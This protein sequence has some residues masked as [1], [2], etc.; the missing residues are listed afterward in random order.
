[1]TDIE[2][3]NYEFLICLRTEA[4]RD[5]PG[6]CAMFGVDV[7]FAKVT[8]EM[9]LTQI[10]AVVG[11]GLLLWRPTMP[12]AQMLRV[13]K[14]ESLT[15]RR[16]VARMSVELDLEKRTRPSDAPD[17]RPS[18]SIDERPARQKKGNAK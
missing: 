2:R 16:I 17:G 6:A 9:T 1:M 10:E 14:L 4:A 5:L 8:S 13:A 18:A 7:D 3:L 12:A 11:S 15:H